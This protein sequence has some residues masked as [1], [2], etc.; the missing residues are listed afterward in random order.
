MH[1]R[2]FK[3][4]KNR[5]RAPERV[6]L[7]EVDRV[8]RISLETFPA[9]N[10]LDVGVGTAIF[11]EAF[12][13]KGLSVAGIDANPEMVEA[14]RELI[15]DGDFEIGIAE[16]IPFPDNT[17]DLVMMSHIL[18]ETDDRIKALQEAHRV[19]RMGRC[20]SRMAL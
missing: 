2:R 9:K 1:E 16:A 4:D 5:L 12:S 3:R 10:I 15:P 17:Y 6:N 11:A 18:H 13:A 20:N 7:L 8:I 19:A 14:S